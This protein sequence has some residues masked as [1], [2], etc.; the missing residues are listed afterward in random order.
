MIGHQ[1]LQLDRAEE[2][3]GYQINSNTKFRGCGKVK[4]EELEIRVA[5]CLFSQK[6]FFFTSFG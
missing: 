3:L 1:K 6:L 4:S 5:K 2:A